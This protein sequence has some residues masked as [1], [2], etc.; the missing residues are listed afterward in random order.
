M[1]KRALESVSGGGNCSGPIDQAACLTAKGQR[2]DFEVETFVAHALRGEGFDASEDGTGRGTPLV[3]VTRHVHPFCETFSVCHNPN[4]CDGNDCWLSRNPDH[5]P[6]S[7]SVVCFSSKDHGA[8]ASE[9]LAPTLRAMV[10]AGSHANAGGQ[11]AV[12]FAI[13]AGALRENP[14][15]GPDGVGVQQDISYT[16]EARAEVQAVTYDLRGR[17]G[18]AQFEGPHDTANIRAASGGS[19]RSYVGTQWAVRRLT[20]KE[21]ARLQGF[22]DDYLDLPHN[23]FADA[24]KYKRIGNSWAV[25][26]V[27]WIGARLNAAMARVQK[28]KKGPASA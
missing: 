20:P 14:Q 3:P 4:E 26:V 2:S 21:C 15:S 10:H 6:Q 17:D 9:D 7:S 13:Q 23:P 27:A 18:G 8:D 5:A 22:P 11:I 16:L 19:S 12:A 1:L 24:P 25:P 28:R